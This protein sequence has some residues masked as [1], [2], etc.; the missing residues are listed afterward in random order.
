MNAPVGDPEYDP[1]N[2]QAIFIALLAAQVI[3]FFMSVFSLE[4]PDFSYEL[5]DFSFTLIPLAA[6]V[7]D[8]VGN[9]IY[10]TG[11]S[12]L[13]TTDMQKTMQRLARIHII[14]WALVE[15]ATLIL[16]VFAMVNENHFFSAFALANL[17]YF[18]TL[19]PKLF[20]FNEGLQ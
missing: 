13:T 16:I 1:K 20:T 11:I 5:T 6:L 3:F 4:N 2:L 12:N 14:R 7:L 18:I 9:R 15:M 19:R 8:I 17:I 10:S